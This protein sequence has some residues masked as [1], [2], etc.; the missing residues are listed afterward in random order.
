MI[1]CLIDS[2]QEGLVNWT[3][4]VH[5]PIII[6]P[7][8]RDLT[9]YV[10]CLLQILTQVITQRNRIVNET[11]N[12]DDELDNDD[13]TTL[14]HS[15][16]PSAEALAKINDYSETERYVGLTCGSLFFPRVVIPCTSDEQADAVT[17][18]PNLKLL[19]RLS[20]FHVLDDGETNYR[21]CLSVID[22]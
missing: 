11:D 20:K 13:D 14:P 17:K 16:E 2:N 12:N 7:T 1:T 4:E 5:L 8:F 18:N 15:K 6:N 19:F 22:P 21:V 3:T 10:L 9:T